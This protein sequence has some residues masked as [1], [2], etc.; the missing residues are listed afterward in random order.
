MQQPLNGKIYILSG[1]TISGLPAVPG[2][3]IS[4]AGNGSMDG[5]MM[6][7]QDP[8]ANQNSA[9]NEPPLSEDVFVSGIPQGMTLETI[10]DLTGELEHLNELVMLHLKK[11]GGFTSPASYFAAVQ[12]ILDLL[13]FEIRF[14]YCPG[15]TRQEM[16]LLVRDWIDEE[17][18]ERKAKKK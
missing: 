7:D 13:E 5:S 17:I 12:P 15:M 10:I 9:G 16:K 8:G 2:I 4:M 11:E 6:P 1:K 14:R 3:T 18:A